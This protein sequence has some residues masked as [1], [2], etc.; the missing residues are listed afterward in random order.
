MSARSIRASDLRDLDGGS[1]EI[2]ASGPPPGS[3]GASGA[4]AAIF[5]AA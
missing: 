4:L 5:Q 2:F 3:V 1:L